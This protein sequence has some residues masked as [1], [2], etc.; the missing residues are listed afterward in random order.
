[1]TCTGNTTNYHRHRAFH[2]VCS[3]WEGRTTTLWSGELKKGL[4][5]VK[6]FFHFDAVTNSRSLEVFSELFLRAL[7]M[8][9][10]FTSSAVL[11]SFRASQRLAHQPI[12]VWSND[13]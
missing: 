10:N 8:G 7:V 11:V 6:L 9:S 3:E 13:S 1:M 2:T 4:E 12:S 5:K